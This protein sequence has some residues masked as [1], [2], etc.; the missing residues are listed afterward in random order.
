MMDAIQTSKFL[1]LILRHKPEAIGIILDPEG[2]A[3][4]EE[5]VA[6]S[7]GRLT[8]ELIDR[9]VEENNK[10]RYAVSEDGKRIRA[11][12][13]HSVKD[14]DL[15]FDPV[16]PPDVLYHGTSS[17]CLQAI[18]VEGLLKMKRHHVHLSADMDTAYKV[19]NR[20]RGTPF[21]LQVDAKKM[22]SDGYKFFRSEN[23]VWLTDSVPRQYIV[24]T[25]MTNRVVGR[26]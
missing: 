15:K 22:H 14:V 3:D 20:H 21:V 7:G 6:K 2:W 23:G 13:G 12:Q 18:Q 5:I 9:A 25:D 17:D 16:E 10:K 26:V 24:P 1:A 19:G 11:R 8:R 4:I